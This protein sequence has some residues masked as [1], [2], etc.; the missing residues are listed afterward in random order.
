MSSSQDSDSRS[1][2]PQGRDSCLRLASGTIAFEILSLL[3]LSPVFL[4]FGT[5]R[6]VSFFSLS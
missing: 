6:T 5:L 3:L 2:I 4:L 1:V